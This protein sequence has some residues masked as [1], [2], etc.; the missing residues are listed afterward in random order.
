MQSTNQ[1][2]ANSYNHYIMIWILKKYWYIFFHLHEIEK[3]KR[4][5]KLVRYTNI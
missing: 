3:E 1:K 5:P 2:L 4:D